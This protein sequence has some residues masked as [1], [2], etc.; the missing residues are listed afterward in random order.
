ML[1]VYHLTI[2]GVL[3]CIC[4]IH[5]CNPLFQ[6]PDEFL[7]NA[8][9][10]QNIIRCNTGLPAVEEFSEHNAFRRQVQ[11]CRTVNNAGAFP[12]QFQRHRRK[13]FRRP[14]HNLT[15]HRYAARKENVVKRLVKQLPVFLPAA[16][17]SQHIFRRETFPQNFSYH[18]RSRGGIRRRLH[19]TA[20]A[21]RQRANQR[22]HA[23]HKR[24]IP[25]RHYQ[26]HAIR[27]FYRKALCGKLCQRR[28]YMPFCCPARQM[29]FYITQFR[30]C[31]TYFRKI[32]FR[33]RFIQIFPQSGADFL[34]IA[35][36]FPPQPFQ[37][38]FPKCQRYCFP[39]SEK[40]LLPLYCFFN[41][42]SCPSFP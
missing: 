16:L 32:A 36:D 21:R 3:P 15:P 26:H 9:F 8:L 1:F 17:H 18:R 22:L 40:S 27:L 41:F 11:L 2:I 25:W 29:F 10:H 12:A 24:V 20:V 19:Y 31:H 30:K 28:Q 33:F 14:F 6:I 7:F 35:K 42:H 37:C 13:V 34:F 38:H 4:A 39:R 23:E 5:H